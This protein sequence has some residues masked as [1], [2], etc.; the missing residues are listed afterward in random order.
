MFDGRAA[1]AD[2]ISRVREFVAKS[3]APIITRLDEF[4]AKLKAIPA[5]PQGYPGLKGDQGIPG[6]DGVPVDPEL[7]RAE[8][9]NAVAELAIPAELHDLSSVFSKGLDDAAIA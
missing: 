6:K 5:G 9:A 2:V 8:V 1:A 3:T 4:D 7:V